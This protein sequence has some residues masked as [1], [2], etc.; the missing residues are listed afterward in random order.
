MKSLL[1][2]IAKQVLFNN[3]NAK[4]FPAVKL[5]FDQINE[6]VLLKQARN[7]IDISERHCIV[8]HRPF[9]MAVWLTAR[10][11]LQ[12]GTDGLTV[13]VLTGDQVSAE[14]TIQ[15]RATIEE[16]D[17]WIVVF[18]IEKGKC[19]QASRFRQFLIRR[20][21][22]KKNTP[23]E[24]KI[25]AA[26]YSYPRKVI[27]VSFRDKA[28]YNIFPMDFQCFIKERN[29]YILGLRTTNITL[30]KIIETSRLVISDTQDANIHDVY[31]LGSHHSSAP[32]PIEKLPFGT[33]DSELLRFPVPDFASS[34]KEL[35]ITTTMELG[36]HMLLIAKVVNSKKLK[37]P[38]S[39]IYHIHF[40]ESFRSH[41]SY[42]A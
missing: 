20:N 40:L 42:L 32:L 31:L 17:D 9:C 33:S 7:A 14:L 6:K 10:E 19:F 11:F 26:M 3:Q 12:D 25:Y 37:S 27:A 16:E 18:T 36:G 41:Y 22:N 5:S 1:K 4:T 29:L 28:Y 15:V 24:D 34:Y 8:C 39:S 30:A 2:T 21:L 13:Q 23:R 35:K 38:I